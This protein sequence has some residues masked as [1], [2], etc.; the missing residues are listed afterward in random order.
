[1]GKFSFL[2]TDFFKR[3]LRL[4]YAFLKGGNTCVICGK[5]T[6]LYLLCDSCFKQNFG[7]EKILSV[8]RCAVCGKELVT[9]E[10][11]CVEC[12]EK[13]VLHHL[14]KMIPMCSY[15]LWN[16]ELL[17]LW[18]MQSIRS[19]SRL[20]AKAVRDL[21]LKLGIKVIV[22][23]PPRPGKIKENGWDQIDE[24]CNY[25]RYEFGFCVLNLLVRKTAEQQKKL[26]RE[27]RLNSIGK[28]YTLCDEKTRFKVLKSYG[29]K[30]PDEVC[31]IDDV[32]TTGA[33]LE[34]CSKI[35]KDMGVQRVLAVSLF[36]VD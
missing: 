11:F 34:S 31:L 12:Q 7:V 28:A 20:F 21:L 6:K 1:M 30:I 24:L 19:M 9:D 15:R 2:V 25:L 29:S 22:P 10:D 36:I 27:E 4:M 18:K 35:L 5:K 16:K 26:N 23:V 13:P 33:T 14:D 17:F 32:S 3:S 8:K